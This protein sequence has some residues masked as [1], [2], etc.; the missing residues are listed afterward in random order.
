MTPVEV[1]HFRFHLERQSNLLH[2]DR[3]HKHQRGSNAKSSNSS[4]LVNPETSRL[5]PFHMAERHPNDI[6]IPNGNVCQEISNLL[7]KCVPDREEVSF[8]GVAYVL[9]VLP[10]L[11]VEGVGTVSL[12]LRE[13]MAGKLVTH[14]HQQRR[15]TW[16]FPVYQVE[17]KNP[18][19]NVGIQTLCTVSAERLGYKGAVLLPVLSKVMLCGPGGQVETH[20]EP[21]V[22][23]CV[24]TLEIQLPS[25]YTGGALVVCKADGKNQCQYDFDRVNSTASFRPH[26]VVHAV[27]TSCTLEEVTSGYRLVITYSLCLPPQSTFGRNTSNQM[28]MDLAK[29][30][31]R[32]TDGNSENVG[33]ISE[34]GDENGILALMLSE[35][36]TKEQ[37]AVAGWDSL[38]DVDRDRF[39]FLSEAN[40]LVS[41]E[42]QLKFYLVHL[43]THLKLGQKKTMEASWYSLSGAMMNSGEFTSTKKFNFLNPDNRSLGQIWNSGEL[44]EDW[45]HERCAIVMWPTATDIAVLLSLMGFAAAVPTI[46]V[47]ESISIIVLRQLLRDDVLGYYHFIR[48]LHGSK[49][50]GLLLPLCQKLV[51]GLVQST[52]VTL[53]VE[54]FKKYF[55]QLQEKEKIEFFPWLVTL[56]RG[57]GWEGVGTSVIRAIDCQSNE[58]S[59]SHAL[60]MT[61]SLSDCLPAHSA[62][63]LFAVKKAKILAQSNPAILA[64]SSSIALLWKHSHA[65]GC[66]SLEVPMD[67]RNMFVQIDGGLL[68]FVVDTVSK[69]MIGSCSPY[70]QATFAAIVLRRRQWLI[71]EI[72]E[73]KKPFTW[74][75]LNANFAN[76]GEIVNFLQGPNDSFELHDFRTSSEAHFL[77]A[78]VRQCIRA[79]IIITVEGQG[80]KAFVKILKTGGEFDLRR[81]EVPKYMAEILRLGYL[82]SPDENKNSD[83]TLTKGTT[84]GVKRS[85]KDEPAVITIE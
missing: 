8:G 78:Q 28:Q 76:I 77:V 24:A 52:D 49:Q 11:T 20:Q 26:Y 64:S 37:I 27:G 73:S 40:A 84:T 1:R 29:A 65:L 9:P 67:I 82:L 70:H 74:Q 41:P 85:R 47:E 81:K 50:G 79:P 59:M 68:G 45:E 42:K 72:I 4:D 6:F 80:L 35:S 60:E 5:W 39:E 71:N 14:G 18:E 57:V 19:W 36:A 15:Q 46:L 75:V 56:V 7:G 12:P 53:A 17:I 33:E 66:Q 23:R 22:E 21:W 43:R 10:G 61:E 62:L 38:S 25:E 32:L 51:T 44:N 2:M 34:S 83:N 16:I 55:D 48:D 3:R 30:I 13:E 54:F 63:T 69:C 31:E 58:V